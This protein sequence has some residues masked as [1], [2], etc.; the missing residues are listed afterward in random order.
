MQS[1][2]NKIKEDIVDRIADVFW[3]AIK[4]AVITSIILILLQLIPIRVGVSQ[5]GYRWD[6]GVSQ[7]DHVW[8]I[9]R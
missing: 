4:A 6:V 5:T 8:S 1:I 2:I 7:S 9:S 3:A